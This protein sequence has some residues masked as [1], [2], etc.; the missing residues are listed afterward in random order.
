MPTVVLLVD[1]LTRPLVPVCAAAAVAGVLLTLG[2]VREHG[3]LTAGVDPG[4]LRRLLRWN[5]ARSLA[6]T[7][8]GVTALVPAAA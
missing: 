5:L 3:R 1:D 8:G 6:W 7:L 2:A 4:V